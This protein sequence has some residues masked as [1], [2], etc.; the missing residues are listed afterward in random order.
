MRI[1]KIIPTVD[2]HTAGEPVRFILGGVRSIPGKTMAEK[3]R[4]F[5]QEL[6]Y[7]RTILLHEPRGHRDMCGALFTPPVSRGAHFGL[8]FFDVGG[9]LDMCGHST[10]GA[11]TAVLEQGMFAKEEPN[12]HLSIDTPAGLVNA[13]VRI[14]DGRVRSVTIRNVASFLFARDVEIKIPGIG[15]DTS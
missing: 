4:F 11:A 7:V 3:Q 8:L 5:S 13:R 14:E 6:D 15:G 2:L 1:E 12:T 10:I 9:H